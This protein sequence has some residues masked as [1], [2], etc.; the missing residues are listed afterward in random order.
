MNIISTFHVLKTLIDRLNNKKIKMYFKSL[1]L[2]FLFIDC[3][4]K[5][6]FLHCLFLKRI[7]EY[8]KISKRK[9]KN[10]KKKTINYCTYQLMYYHVRQTA[11]Y[12]F[13]NVEN[14]EWLSNL[15]KYTFINF[16]YKKIL[17]N[18]MKQKTNQHE[19]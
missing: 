9:G 8:G 1:Q 17:W 2:N 10:Q 3:H 6:T 7:I 15:I 5:W 12:Q 4:E 11:T 14:T 19:Q 16:N 18:Y 13:S